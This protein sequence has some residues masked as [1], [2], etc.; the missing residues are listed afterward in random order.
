MDFCDVD[1]SDIQELRV[2]TSSSKPGSA[3]QYAHE[4]GARPATKKLSLLSTGL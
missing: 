1:D 4:I 2:L 3:K